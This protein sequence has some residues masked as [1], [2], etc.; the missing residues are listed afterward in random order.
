MVEAGRF[1]CCASAVSVLVTL[2]LTVNPGSACLLLLLDYEVNSV[3]MP[4]R[5]GFSLPLSLSPSLLSRCATLLCLAE[6]DIFTWH[7]THA[8]CSHL[9]ILTVWHTQTRTHG[10]ACSS[11]HSRRPVCAVCW[12]TR[13]NL[14]SRIYL[15][16]E[17]ALGQTPDM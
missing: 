17:D 3:W 10:N 15:K 1:R 6:I 4:S 2:H 13:F 11:S 9:L 7:H 12:L 16:S 5:N 14:L 8:C